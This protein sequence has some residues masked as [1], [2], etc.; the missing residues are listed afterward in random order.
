MLWVFLATRLWNTLT[1][2]TFMDE[3]SMISRARFIERGQFV[4][5]PLIRKGK[6]LQPAAMSLFSPDG[7]ESL[8]LSRAVSAL[9]ALFSVAACISLGRM[10]AS[11]DVGRLAG[12][13]YI[14][15]ALGFFIERSAV[16]EVWMA[17]FSALALALTVRMILT[18]QTR[19]V[20][21]LGLTMAAAFLSKISAATLLGV[22]LIAAWVLVRRAED[23]WTSILRS[24]LSVAVSVAVVLTL[25]AAALRQNPRRA[26]TTWQSIPFG[27]ACDWS[28]ICEGIAPV[29]AEVGDNLG[30][31]TTYGLWSWL[32]IGPPM[33]ALAISS[34][35]FLRGARGRGIVFLWLTILIRAV[36]LIAVASWLPIRNFLSLLVPLAVLA[37]MT[38]N[39]FRQLSHRHV[40]RPLLRKGIA[41]V[42][43]V[44][45]L[46][47]PLWSLPLN[48]AFANKPQEVVVPPRDPYGCEARHR[49]YRYGHGYLEV[50]QTLQDWVASNRQRANVVAEHQRHMLSYWGPRVGDVEQW[51]DESDSLR[52][53]VA[54][55]LIESESVFFV[56]ELPTRSIPDEPFGAIL[57][58]V[59]IHSIPCGDHHRS[60]R[61]RR[62]VADSPELRRSIYEI[63]FPSPNDVAEQYRAI[64]LHLI[65]T[66]AEGAVIV[67]PPNQFDLLDDRLQWGTE[68][69]G[70]YA[71]GDMWPLDA[72]LVEEELEDLSAEHRELHVIL[73]AEESGD[74]AHVIETWLNAHMQLEQELGFGPVRVLNFIPQ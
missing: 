49:S 73:L 55:W 44:G 21:P 71:L 31:V 61:V 48:V 38:I 28:E 8:W 60:I 30:N 41:I 65:D 66:Q 45:A 62:L 69:N 29:L 36:P 52:V 50:S 72:Q 68:L 43:A 46:I 34:L 17:G 5:D 35:A 12:A 6:W 51:E 40:R 70:V 26:A 3:G 39:E 56:D 7:P 67:Y 14:F 58:P 20:L 47:A 15:P 37:A 57:E 27:S 59:A 2:P 25:Y 16:S 24:G 18:R 54:Q 9:L 23:R 32:L 64:A 4:F 11:R 19:Y 22:P 10:L 13:F 53:K 74:P 33:L 63:V 1:L 42:I